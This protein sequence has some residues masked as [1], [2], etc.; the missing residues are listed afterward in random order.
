MYLRKA[1]F[2]RIYFCERSEQAAA[3]KRPGQGVESSELRV[4][5][6]RFRV[7]LRKAAF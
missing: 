7:Y 2:L 3:K 4:G 5:G 6:V 1:A